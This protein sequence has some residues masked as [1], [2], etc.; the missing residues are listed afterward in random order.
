M[1][2]KRKRVFIAA[3][4]AAAALLAAAGIYG[5]LTSGRE[6]RMN[7]GPQIAGGDSGA[8]AG[9]DAGAA[10]LAGEA[11]GGGEAGELGES[12]QSGAGAEADTHASE[13]AADSGAKTMASTTKGADSGAKTTQDSPDSQA[14]VFEYDFSGKTTVLPTP[15]AKKLPLWKGFNLL[16]FFNTLSYQQVDEKKFALLSELGFNFVR[17]PIDY[18]CMIVRGDWDVLSERALQQLDKAVGY[19]IKHDIHICINLHRAPG[20]TVATPPE[21]T[22]L[23][24]QSGPQEAFARMWGAF[25]ERYKNVPNEYL[26]FNL[27]NEPPDIAENVYVKVMGK[28][29]E[30]IWARDP[31]RLLIAD[32][33][34][35]GQKPSK[36]I[37]EL[38]IAQATRGYQPFNLTH[39]KAEWV[40]GADRYPAPGWPDF[41]IP[42]YL[43][44][45]NQSASRSVWAI[46]Y[47]FKE[48]YSLGIDV[49][50][51]SDSARLIVKADGAAVYS[52]D[53]VS[54]AGKGEWTKEVYVDEWK[55]YQNIYDKV[56]YAEIPAGTQ[57]L[58]LEVTAGDW[59]SINKLVF[60]PSSGTGKE[61]AIAPNNADWGMKA[62]ALLRLDADGRLIFDESSAR[63]RQWLRETYL[64]PW[65]ALM[66]SGCGVMV[67]EWGAYNK[68]PHGVVLGWMEDCLINFR[69]AGVGWALWNFDDAFGPLNSRRADVEY[70]DFEGFKADRK[71]LD[72]LLKY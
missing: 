28:A 23:W 47:D 44:G 42:I 59:M 8:G 61:F 40:N 51:V 66:E 38:G 16:Y 45:L 46:E 69:D 5:A 18:R 20:Y 7:G 14:F 35:W 72:L 13:P 6:R 29:A 34:A 11:D 10:G 30:A 15:T 55:I 3:I 21:E 71:M 2:P 17:L 63:G 68:T 27:V 43:Y 62:P 67:G 31:G 56:Y 49:G 36:L 12:G 26:S 53:F 4:I 32:G 50:I 52:H 48:A 70:E 9:A 19:G 24:R 22:D 39:Y 57:L 33:I 65:E 1:S 41:M 64:K 25:A 37:K 58:T 60:A 54:K